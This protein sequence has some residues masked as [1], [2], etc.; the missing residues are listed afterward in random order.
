MLL[1]SPVY[2]LDLSTYLSGGEG[3]GR[4]SYLSSRTHEMVIACWATCW[5]LTLIHCSYHVLP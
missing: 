4:N 3:E 2:F 1:I 5:E